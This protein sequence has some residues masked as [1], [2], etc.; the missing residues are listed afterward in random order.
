MTSSTTTIVWFRQDLRLH[1]NPALAAA[2]AKGP[3][4]PLYI[5]DDANPGSAWRLGGASRWWLH[6]SLTALRDKLGAI[7]LLRGDPRELVPRLAAEAVAGAVVWNRC[8]EPYAV[9]RDTEVKALLGKS[10]VAVQSFNGSLLF[11]PWEIKTGAGGSFKVYTPFLRACLG[12]DIPT[13]LPAPKRIEIAPTRDDGD[14]LDDWHLVPRRPN[15]A[16][17]WDDIW[18]PGEKGALARLDAFIAKGLAGYKEGRDRP[19]RANVSRLSPHLHFG[20]IA[21]RSLWARIAHAAEDGANRQSAE[22]F[23]SELIW[24][25][26]CYHLLYHFPKL[27]EENW[28][29]EFDA[30]PW[31]DA[32]ADLAAWQHGRTG[33]PLV[34][35]G[36][37]ELWQ[38]GFMHN[39]VRMIAA[40]FLIKH[41]RIDWRRGE[42]WFWD[43]LV[44]A[45]LAN[46]A[47]GWQWVAGSGADASP[48]FRIFNPVTQG[49]KFDPDGHYVRRFCPE[50]ARLPNAFIH[51]PFEAPPDVLAAAGIKLG[52]TYP[53]PIVE[54]RTARQAALAGYQK[55]R[56]GKT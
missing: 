35:A 10:G 32:D 14:R 3:V 28:H 56:A 29:G 30:Y 34:D 48:Y 12:R 31:R 40:S 19:D 4:I 25:E 26:F 17:G 20:E 43:T 1:D 55:V 53:L 47:A 45:D 23:R 36:M 13:P 38:T 21:P 50:L 41:L 27:A 18:Q 51:A 11:E 16:A 46:N 44:D 37:R 42:A 49:R 5:L 52:E 9:K 8:Y 2:A 33:Y 54:H 24:R 15:W 6:H 7:V 39:R 22:K